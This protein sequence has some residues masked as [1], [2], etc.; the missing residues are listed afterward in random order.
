[1]FGSLVIVF[2]TKHE[3]GALMLRHGGSEWIFDSATMIQ[4]QVNPSITYVAFYSDVEHEVTAVTSGYRVT[5]TYNLSFSTGPTSNAAPAIP[6]PSTTEI[7]FKRALSMLLSDKTFMEQ[8]GF[9]GFGLQHE[10]PLDPKAGLGNLINCLKGSDAIIQRVCSQLC[11]PTHLCVIY[12]D[13][14][15]GVSF[16]MVKDI[17]D[18]SE[19]GQFDV[20]TIGEMMTQDDGG[21]RIAITGPIADKAGQYSYQGYSLDNA[22]YK[23]EDNYVDVDWV[24][25]LTKFTVAETPYIAYGNE[26]QIDCV[27]LA[28]FKVSYRQALT[29]PHQFPD[30]RQ[31]RPSRAYRSAGR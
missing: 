27:G 28:P 16:V 10:Y 11:L 7:A 5:L 22:V 4:T 24:T 23:S 30:V 14:I 31:R 21:K 18:Y 19:H 25:D 29:S 3:G 26:P 8:G 12:Q 20:M 17:I 15:E 6:T 1:M 13:N 2:P 9:L